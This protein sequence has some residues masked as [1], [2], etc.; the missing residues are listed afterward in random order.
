MVQS[1][2]R[3]QAFRGAGCLNNVIREFRSHGRVQQS[4]L[5]QSCLRVQAFRGQVVLKIEFVSSEATVEFS[6]VFELS[7][8]EGR[9]FLNSQFASSD[10]MIESF[11]VF[12]FPLSLKN[13]W[14]CSG[15]LARA[16]K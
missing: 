12:R 5:V 13:N 1:C 6:I 9:S 2:P 11:S 10:S 14:T 8:L 7:H 15:D 16:E 3:V 4:T